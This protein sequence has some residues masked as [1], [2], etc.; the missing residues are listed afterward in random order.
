MTPGYM[1]DIVQRIAPAALQAVQASELGTPPQEVVQ[2]AI[3]RN[4]AHSLNQVLELSPAIAELLSSQQG[5]GFQ[6]LTAMYSQTHGT[7]EF[8]DQR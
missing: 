8:T 7:V 5:Q 1:Q 6:A 3:R 2:D 4:A